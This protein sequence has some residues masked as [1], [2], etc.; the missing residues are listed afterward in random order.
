MD[1]QTTH[2]NLIFYLD[3][4]LPAEKHNRIEQH[5]RNC[6][7]CREFLSF[8]KMEM[9]VISEEKN[10]EVSPYFYTRLSA[11]LQD[12]AEYQP[13]N[14]W[15]RIVQPAFFSILLLLAIYGGL[16]IGTYTSSGTN[17]LPAANTSILL[18]NDF[19]A[20][21]IESFILGQL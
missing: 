20:E 2:D 16:Q 11:K 15:L 6:E 21:P 5:L 13:A 10:P 3:N 8:L 17:Q 9:Q 12:H 18:M 1:C 7:D 14:P 4:E 19:E